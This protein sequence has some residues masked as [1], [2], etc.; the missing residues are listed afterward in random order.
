MNGNDYQLHSPTDTDW[1]ANHH[2]PAYAWRLAGSFADP[3]WL[4]FVGVLLLP[5]LLFLP[6][7][8]W[9]RVSFFA[10][11]A[12]YLGVLKWLGWLVFTRPS[13]WKRTFLLFPAELFVGLA[14]LC[15]WFYLRNLVGWLRPDL[16]SL[17]ELAI[18][19]IAVA[20]LHVAVGIGNFRSWQ[21]RSASSAK[22]QPRAE[23]GHRQWLGQRLVIY[24]PFVFLL[25]C[26]FWKVS[27]VLHVQDDD[28]VIHA[29]SARVYLNDGVFFRRFNG[30]GPIAYPAG[31]GAINAVTVAVSPLTV[32]QA[33]NFQHVFLV[34]TAC[35]LVT[36][37]VSLL[38]GR[39][40]WL[41]HSLSL[42]FLSLFPLYALYPYLN[43]EGTSRQAAIAFFVVVCL[44]PTLIA[45]T[46][47]IPFFLILGVQAI[48]IV[49][50]VA[51]NPAC[52]PFVALAA[53]ISLVVNCCKGRTLLGGRYGGVL[54]L[55]GIQAALLLLASLLILGC[56]EYYRPIFL[57]MVAGQP[58]RAS[59]G[60]PERLPPA[61][62]QRPTLSWHPA[63]FTL[64]AVVTLLY[65]KHASRNWQ[66][67]PPFTWFPWMGLGLTVAVGFG[68]WAGRRTKAP[69]LRTNNS[70]LSMLALSFGLWFVIK[71]MSALL[72]SAIPWSAPDTALLSSY[73]T[74]FAPRCEL[75][76][77]FVIMAVSIACLYQMA[78]Q[79]VPGG[80]RWRAI[81]SAL[82]VPLVAFACASLFLNPY[83]SGQVVAE[84]WPVEDAISPKDVRLVAWADANII[85]ADGIIGLTARPRFIGQGRHEK[86]IYPLAGGQ[87]FLFY[88]KGYNFCFTDFDPNLRDAFSNYNFYIKD[89]FNAQ[90]CLDN[91]IRYFFVPKQKLD[92]DNQGITQAIR[93]GYL[94]PLEGDPEGACIYRV[95]PRQNGK[96]DGV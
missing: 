68:L 47:L 42:P 54:K 74:V 89:T 71:Y 58:L 7:G 76:I 3:E 59:S 66:V 34:I 81:T 63:R 87:A 16:Y 80:A 62:T 37:A 5:A 8:D 18:L 25:T 14:L 75:L 83:H 1:P 65:E 85:P 46:R 21:G 28:P 60:A 10:G 67:K 77:I 84:S 86:H 70:L 24:F 6:R 32:V 78:E 91:N 4:L 38:S 82:A 15:L 29:Y 11:A 26:A 23:I 31:F 52:V 44:L 13:T 35:F 72:A 43:Y 90:W 49:L 36:S 69:P 64:E 19:P 51:F 20:L 40:L 22:S 45:V 96:S 93:D 50:T 95:A 41:L 30:N 2:P 57:R 79:R 17:K 55:V 33:L 73:I 61:A 48:L 88:S 39:S 94:V 56:D 53:L 27:S 9:Q 92:E 12:I